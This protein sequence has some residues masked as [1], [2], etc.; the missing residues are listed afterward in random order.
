MVD[1]VKFCHNIL[2]RYHER[3]VPDICEPD[4]RKEGCRHVSNAKG[5]LETEGRDDSRAEFFTI[6]RFKGTDI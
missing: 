3:L 6:G 5:G 1:A 4:K 2:H